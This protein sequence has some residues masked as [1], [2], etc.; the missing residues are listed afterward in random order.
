MIRKKRSPPH[1]E[2]NPATGAGLSRG[3]VAGIGVAAIVGTCI[4][5]FVA[6]QMVRFGLVLSI[7]Y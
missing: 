2:H 1:T 5:I 3:V 4:V 6:F 7:A